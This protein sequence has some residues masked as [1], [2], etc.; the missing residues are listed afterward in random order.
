MYAGWRGNLWGSHV[1]LCGIG[2]D[3]HLGYVCVC[4]LQKVFAVLGR[5]LSVS[6]SLVQKKVLL[7]Q[8]ENSL[9]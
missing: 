1:F 9:G 4:V 8:A 2:V 5:R 6:L 7:Q 3:V